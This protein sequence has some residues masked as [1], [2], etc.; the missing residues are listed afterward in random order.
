MTP[1]ARSIGSRPDLP[2]PIGALAR[3]LDAFPGM[4]IQRI[5]RCEGAGRGIPTFIR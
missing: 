2:F 4:H 5:G 1:E 3:S